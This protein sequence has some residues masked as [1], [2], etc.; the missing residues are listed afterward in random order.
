[1][2]APALAHLLPVVVLCLRSYLAHGTATDYMWQE[3]HVPVPMTWEV[4][5]DQKA[6]FEVRE[7]PG[8][9]LLCRS[10]IA[11]TTTAPG[12]PGRAGPASK[13]RACPSAIDSRV[14]R[15]A[16]L[17]G[18]DIPPPPVLL[19]PSRPPGRTASACSTR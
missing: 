3:L 8:P 15:W 9:R 11:S 5:G 4:Y 6:H 16:C 1:M 7:A 17:T 19:C 10:A 13:G 18:P 12:S 14:R 2:L